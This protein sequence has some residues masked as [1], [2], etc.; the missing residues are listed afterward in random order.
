MLPPAG[1]IEEG[2]LGGGV[3][4]RLMTRFGFCLTSS[5]VGRRGSGDLGAG[6][7]TAG[8]ASGVDANPDLLADGLASGGMGA[9]GT[10]NMVLPEV[11]KLAPGFAGAPGQTLPFA[12]WS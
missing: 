4:S 9:D 2:R 1:L 3:T 7:L 6:S 5:A 8:G 11:C 10:P 12:S